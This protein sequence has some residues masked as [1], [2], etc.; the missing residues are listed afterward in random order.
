MPHRR[1]HSAEFRF[2]VNLVDVAT[3]IMKCPDIVYVIGW[4]ANDII[5]L[6]WLHEISVYAFPYWNH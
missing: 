1:A 3:D 5:V 2:C 4:L 6:R